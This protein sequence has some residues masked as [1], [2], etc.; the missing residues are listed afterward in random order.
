[1]CSLSSSFDVSPQMEPKCGFLFGMLN[2]GWWERPLLANT[3]KDGEKQLVDD[4][5]NV[6]FECRMR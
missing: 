3:G 1:M 5:N 2:T 6:E 4:T